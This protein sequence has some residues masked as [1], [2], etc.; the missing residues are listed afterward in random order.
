MDTGL[1][2]VKNTT[3]ETKMEPE[4][5]PFEKDNHLPNLIFL[6]SMLVF[7][8]VPFDKILQV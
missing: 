5:H 3:Q 1:I 6:A 4:N 7:G 2:F 8:G